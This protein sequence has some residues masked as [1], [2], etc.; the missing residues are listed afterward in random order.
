MREKNG[1]Q[2]AAKV[3]AKGQYG[4]G[5]AGMFVMPK[6]EVTNVRGLRTSVRT[7]CEN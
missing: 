4:E 3:M 6:T 7:Y 1:M 5:S 2:T